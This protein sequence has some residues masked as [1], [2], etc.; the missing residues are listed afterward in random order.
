MLKI[1]NENNFGLI[2]FNLLNFLALAGN[3]ASKLKTGFYQRVTEEWP[4]YY[5]SPH[6]VL[7][8][9]IGL[10]CYALVLGLGIFLSNRKPKLST[11]LLLLPLAICLIGMY[12]VEITNLQLDP[13]I[14]DKIKHQHY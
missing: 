8:V 7:I 6:H 4:W 11:A 9:T 3:F 5:Q 14:Q 13:M 12:V 1:F 10:V 2:V